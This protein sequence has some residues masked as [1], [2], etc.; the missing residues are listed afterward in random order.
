V[1]EN[2][3]WLG[4]AAFQITNDKVIYIDPWKLRGTEE[5]ADIILITHDHYDH[6]EPKDVA[7]IQKENTIIVTTADC[8]RKLSGDVRVISPGQRLDLDGVIVEAVP[9]Y[10]VDKD[11]HPRA[12]GWVGFVVT[13]GGR[14]IYHTGDS[15]L[16]DE[17]KAVQADILLLPIGGTYTMTA[18]QAAQAANAI[19]PK[20]AIPMHYGTI[21]GSDDDAARFE[22][23]CQVPVKKLTVQ[24]LSGR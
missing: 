12:N 19:H 21:V 4:H 23:L 11:F 14:R 1:V 24:K 6:C 5:K 3:R 8:A 17:M 10:N 16:T 2:I 9:A 20:W 7:K 13:T 22:E 15:D 18:E